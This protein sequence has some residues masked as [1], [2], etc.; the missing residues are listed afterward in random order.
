MKMIHAARVATLALSLVG[1]GLGT[2][3]AH[4]SPGLAPSPTTTAAGSGDAYE[5]SLARQA[6]MQ[7]DFEVSFA[8]ARRGRTASDAP[9]NLRPELAVKGERVHAAR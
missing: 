1:V 2:G 6:S 4:N 7:D 9:M 8:P 3:C 5:P